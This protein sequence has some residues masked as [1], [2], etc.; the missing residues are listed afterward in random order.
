MSRQH[1]AAFEWRSSASAA[2]GCDNSIHCLAFLFFPGIGSEGSYITTTTIT[3]RNIRPPPFSAF[4]IAL[5]PYVSSGYTGWKLLLLLL[6][7]LSIVTPP[8]SHLFTRYIYSETQWHI[9]R[10]L[11]QAPFSFVTLV[12]L[13]TLPPLRACGDRDVRVKK[14]KHLL[15]ARRIIA[16]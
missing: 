8:H 15:A 12:L 6:F 16:I 5:V 9:L 11:F 10:F 3:R 13:S 14:K 1:A 4:G 2:G 7:S